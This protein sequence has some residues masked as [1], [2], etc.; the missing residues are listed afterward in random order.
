ML[1]VII[2]GLKIY[3]PKKIESATLTSASATLS[4][5]RF[6]YKSS[7]S[8][9]Q[10]VGDITIIIDSDSADDDTNHLFPNDTICFSNAAESGCIGNRTYTV[11][12][13]INTTNFTITDTLDNALVDTDYIVATASGTLTI[14]FTTVGEIP[15]GGD[16]IVTIPSVNT[17]NKTNDGIPDTGATTGVNGF[18]ISNMAASNVAMTN[19]TFNA[20][21]I[22]TAGGASADTT[23]VATTTAACAASTTLT[24]TISD[25]KLIN[26]APITSHTRGQADVYTLNVKTR[27]ISDNTID[28]VNT[29]AAPVEAVLISATV[30]ETLSFTVA[31][32]ASAT[33][34]CG[35]TTSVTTT[36]TSVPWGTLSPTY[37]SGTHNAAQQLTI[38][39][40]ADAGYKVYIE[41]NDQMGKNGVTCTGA[42]AGESLNCIQ[43]TTC[44]A[45][46]CSHTTAYDWTADPSSYPGLGYSLEN[47]SGTD[48]KFVYNSAASPCNATAGAGVYC[49]KQAA[50]QE[51][52]GP[53]ESRS[54]TNAEIM[55]NSGSVDGS[56]VYVCYRI[57]ITAT[58]P[59]GYYYNKVKYTA[60]PTF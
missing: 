48:A 16:V 52:T 44:N 21:E 41:E 23:I 19:C 8:T 43:D 4:N 29:K 56:S 5:S 30:D 24:M 57:D 12:T 18:D 14:T 6:S 28:E 26:P 51:A 33:S 20:T 42:G 55:T 13:V 36:A 50:D 46:G 38:S 60:I 39:T 2:F 22:I 10:S 27:D 17:N 47:S 40:N 15:S 32:R 7:I 45:T 11:G 31:A 9:T 53:P 3:Q 34:N 58:Q 35:V 59:S 1:A 25:N 49:A 54:D 37:A